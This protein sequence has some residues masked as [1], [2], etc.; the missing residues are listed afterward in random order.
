MKTLFSVQFFDL[1]LC[2][3]AALD[4]AYRDCTPVEFSCE[5]KKCIKKEWRCNLA[6][7]CGDNSDEINCRMY[8]T[9]IVP[10]VYTH[11]HV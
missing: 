1:C 10:P 9:H 2:V 4:G 11:A 8:S 3:C 6:D 7:E 5:N